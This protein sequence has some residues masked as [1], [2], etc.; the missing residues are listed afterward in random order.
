MWMIK[1]VKYRKKITRSNKNQMHI[2]VNN[3]LCL[4]NKMT[5]SAPTPDDH[6][7]LESIVNLFKAIEPS[8]KRRVHFISDLS[9]VL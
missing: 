9:P 2:I 7:E 4:K 6:Q 5:T 3:F 1:L 8:Q